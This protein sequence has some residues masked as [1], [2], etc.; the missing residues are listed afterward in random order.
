MHDPGF[1]SCANDPNI[2]RRNHPN[3]A[4]RWCRGLPLP[5]CRWSQRHVAGCERWLPV[6]VPIMIWALGRDRARLPISGPRW[7]ASQNQGFSGTT[8]LNLS[9]WFMRS[10]F[11]E[12]QSKSPA[13]KIL[14]RFMYCRPQKD[15][16]EN[17]RLDVAFSS[18]G[19]HKSPTMQESSNTKK[20]QLHYQ[21]V[22][23]KKGIP[24]K[25]DH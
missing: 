7:L 14:V 24:P 22:A 2:S 10:S 21:G 17:M 20:G 13:E 6:P 18:G 11:W 16:R 9:G 25:N 5:L 3:H 15:R 12:K 23:E 19:H 8:C 4:P 1:G